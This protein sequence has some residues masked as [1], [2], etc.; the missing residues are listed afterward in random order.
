MSAPST[1]AESTGIRI[2]G[3]RLTEEET[4]ALLLVV[5]SLQSAA[6]TSTED[7][8]DPSAQASRR[9]RMSTWAGSEVRT[10]RSAAGLR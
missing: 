4:A 7:D 8:A 2:T 3:S 10:W 6:H 5:Q 9:R 1:E